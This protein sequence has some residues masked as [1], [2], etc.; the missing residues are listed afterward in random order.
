MPF[1][2][3]RPASVAAA[4]AL[5]LPTINDSPHTRLPHP[6]RKSDDNEDSSMNCGVA[7]FATERS[8]FSAQCCGLWRRWLA[9]GDRG[10][11]WRCESVRGCHD[12]AASDGSR[13]LKGIR[14]RRPFASHGATISATL[15]A[16]AAAP[17]GQEQAPAVAR[18]DDSF[19][20]KTVAEPRFCLGHPR[21]GA[22]RR[23]AGDAFRGKALAGAGGAGVLNRRRSDHRLGDGLKHQSDRPLRPVPRKHPCLLRIRCR[24]AE[25][26]LRSALV[27]AVAP[28]AV[29]DPY[30]RVD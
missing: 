14:S 2:F 20:L 4:A 23:Q 11:S 15:P 21:D 18:A 13:H 6:A 26:C 3:W 7:K 25:W 22:A 30:R 28:R 5:R 9:A 24:G 1:R 19:C 27:R 12:S 8:Q 29:I 16:A 10:S 17:S